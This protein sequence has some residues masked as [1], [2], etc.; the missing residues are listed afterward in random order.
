MSK[1]LLFDKFFKKQQNWFIVD[2]DGV[3]LEFG[4]NFKR[5]LPEVEDECYL[6][7]LLNFDSN[8]AIFEVLESQLEFNEKIVRINIDGWKRIKNIGRNIN[9]PPFFHIENE[10]IIVSVDYF[11]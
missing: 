5:V 11:F 10:Y 2:R 7:N 3:I 4:A 1:S 6:R 8:K 9:L